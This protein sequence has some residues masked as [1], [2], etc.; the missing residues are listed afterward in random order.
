MTVPE[1]PAVCDQVEKV[2]GTPLRNAMPVVVEGD[3]VT[4]LDTTTRIFEDLVSALPLT[5]DIA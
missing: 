2:T 5:A 3:T 4:W 1:A